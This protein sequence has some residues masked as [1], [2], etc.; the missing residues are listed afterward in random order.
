MRLAT[1]ALI[2]LLVTG[3]NGATSTGPVTVTPAP[4]PTDSPAVDSGHVAFANTGTVAARV[5]V[6]V[7]EGTVDR[8]ALVF[9]NGTTRVR[10]TPRR[11]VRFDT[12]EGVVV[13]IEPIGRRVATEEV[14]IRPGERRVVGVPP[15]GTTRTFLV[16]IQNGSLTRQ[17]VTATGGWTVLSD[18]LLVTCKT[19]ATQRLELRVAGDGV[20]EWSPPC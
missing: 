20:T 16:E 19:R 2:V 11:I 12:S 18:A 17:V 3:C 14:T 7:L 1:G 4:A 9:L 10:A 15:L 6:T 5:T 8:V 13:A